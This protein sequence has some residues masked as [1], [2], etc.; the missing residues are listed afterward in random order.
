MHKSLKV[1]TY[2]DNIFCRLSIVSNVEHENV[3]SFQ[4]RCKDLPQL[5]NFTAACSC[6]GDFQGAV[7]LIQCFIEALRYLF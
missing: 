3:Y 2:P 4:Y 5:Q 1:L 7:K 6:A